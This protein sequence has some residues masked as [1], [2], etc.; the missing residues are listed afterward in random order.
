LE[1]KSQYDAVASAWEIG[2]LKIAV[3]SAR[4]LSSANIHRAESEVR[5]E[6]FERLEH[7][8]HALV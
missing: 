2:K 1:N 6:R 3:R 4:D 5:L 7:F 8:E